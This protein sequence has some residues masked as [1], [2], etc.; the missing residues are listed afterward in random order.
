[1][2][3]HL[4]VTFEAVTPTTIYSVIFPVRVL[5]ALRPFYQ[6]FSFRG[7]VDWLFIWQAEVVAADNANQECS[8]QKQDSRKG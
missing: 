4:F 6:L 1:M 2:N 3:R 7:A 8:R 5:R